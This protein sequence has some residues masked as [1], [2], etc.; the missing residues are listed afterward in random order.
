MSRMISARIEDELCIQ[1]SDIM[2]QLGYTP[3]QL[4][5]SAYGFMVENRCLPYEKKSTS[6]SH[7]IDESQRVQLQEFF[8]DA[9]F[10][11]DALS[12]MVSS[13]DGTEYDNLLIT[14]LEGEYENIR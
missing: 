9:I 6:S 7:A 1:A 11:T 4:I 8:A 12:N 10:E 2:K 3:T 5:S 13:T 14:A